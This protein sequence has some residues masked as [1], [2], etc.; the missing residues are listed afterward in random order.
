MYINLTPKHPKVNW[1]SIVLQ[2][3]IHPRHQF[4]LWLAAWRRL[5]RAE[6]LKKF[7]IQVPPECSYCAV[8]PETFDHLFFECPETRALWARLL[9]WL[10]I[11]RQIGSWQVEL[12]WA[13]KW[14]RK[15][16][17]TGA[18]NSCV[19]A[20]MVYIIWRERNT[21]RFQ[22]MPYQCDRVCKEIGLYIHVRGRDLQKWKE[23]L[24]K[25]DQ[26]P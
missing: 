25:I 20:M 2:P 19:F 17:G 9:K 23:A 12:E 7:V 8:A 11:N 24:K 6:R 4:I 18:I 15:S 3:N 21:I 1:K 5:A 13:N 22:A 14:A 26:V 16:N 10:G